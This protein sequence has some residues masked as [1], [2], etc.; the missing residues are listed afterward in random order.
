MIDSTSVR[1][2]QQAATAKKG[3]DHCFGRSRRGLTIKIR[4]VLDAQAS[5]SGSA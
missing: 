2:Y 1:A 3:G 4:V 5:R